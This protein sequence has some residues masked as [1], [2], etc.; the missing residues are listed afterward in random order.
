MKGRGKWSNMGKN[1]YFSNQEHLVCPKINKMV[2]SSEKKYEKINIYF[3]LTFGLVNPF[4]NYVQGVFNLKYLLIEFI[5]PNLRQIYFE[6]Q[7]SLKRTFKTVFCVLNYLSILCSRVVNSLRLFCSQKAGVKFRNIDF[8][9][10]KKIIS[11]YTF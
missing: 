11:F 3:K 9:Y 7:K 2:N 6:Y 1:H 8:W 5:I 10:T 4:N